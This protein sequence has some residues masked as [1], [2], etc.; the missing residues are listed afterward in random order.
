[1]RV[2]PCAD[3]IIVSA[4]FVFLLARYKSSDLMTMTSDVS[5]TSLGV[6]VVVTLV[7]VYLPMEISG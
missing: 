5:D 7:A 6:D 2:I 1:M 4:N 3:L